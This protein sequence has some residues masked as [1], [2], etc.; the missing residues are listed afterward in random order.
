MKK[1]HFTIA[2]LISFF[3]TERLI[4]QEWLSKLPFSKESLQKIKEQSFLVKEQKTQS[5]IIFKSKSQNLENAYRYLDINYTKKG[6]IEDSIFFN[7]N[8]T[9]KK[10]TAYH[11]NKKHLIV[12]KAIFKG[13][14]L[15]KQFEY[16]YSKKNKIQEILFLDENDELLNE[17]TFFF[18]KNRDTK[19]T[20][21]HLDFNKN[22]IHYYTIYK[23]KDGKTDSIYKYDQ[24]NNIQHRVYFDIKDNKES[25][26][27]IDQYKTQ[28]QIIEHNTQGKITKEDFFIDS[29]LQY[30]KKYFYNPNGEIS[31]IKQENTNNEILY[32]LFYYQY[33]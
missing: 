5:V 7:K 30:S 2:I 28:K 16:Y 10:R 9:V 14:T 27:T 21:K 3:F 29:K 32:Y 19:I 24:L 33:F 12:E 8:G 15:T 17:S 25:I 22:L 26:I 20:A 6:D 18:Y 13:K 23:Q 4:G 31:Y 11:Y 1:I